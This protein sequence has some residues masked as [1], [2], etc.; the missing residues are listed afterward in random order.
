[1]LHDRTD[2]FGPDKG[3]SIFFPIYHISTNQNAEFQKT[4]EL[5][6]SH[7]LPSGEN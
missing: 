4:H 3:V 2:K 5:D 1:M 6:M 7:Y